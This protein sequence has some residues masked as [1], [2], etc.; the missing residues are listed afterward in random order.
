MQTSIS[1]DIPHN[2]RHDEQW[3]THVEGQYRQKEK[4]HDGLAAAQYQHAS[5]GV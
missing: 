2:I 1:S 3:E 4:I 5:P